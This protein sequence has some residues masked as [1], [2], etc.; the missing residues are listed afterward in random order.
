MKKLIATI[1]LMGII[2][3][4][5]AAAKTGIFMA[6]YQSTDNPQPQ[7]CSNSKM[8]TNWGI[9]VTGF[10]GI[11][12]TAFEGIIVIQGFTRTDNKEDSKAGCR[13]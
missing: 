9:F 4:G 8:R 12:V 6:D 10:A 7:T 5:N 3:M 13:I 1:G 2:L 11:F